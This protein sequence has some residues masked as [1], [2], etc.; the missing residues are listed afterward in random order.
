MD[1]DTTKEKKGDPLPGTAEIPREYNHVRMIS[2]PGTFGTGAQQTP[3][4]SVQRYLD[5]E[6]LSASPPPQ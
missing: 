1:G 4:I 6:E 3:S 5:I 2:L